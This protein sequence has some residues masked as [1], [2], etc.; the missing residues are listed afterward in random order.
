MAV[1]M[2]QHFTFS[3]LI[4]FALPTVGM[5]LFM[6]AYAMV[7]GFFVSNFAGKTALAAVN[8]VYPI[9]MIMG[10]V[11][12]M[13]GTGG[14]AVVAKT[15]GEG[16]PARANR[17]FSL[18]VYAAITAAVVFTVIGFVA[19]RPLLVLMGAEEALFG[20]AM[21]YGV[22]LMVGIPFSILQ[23]LFQELLITAG[24]PGLGFAITVAAGVTNIVLDAV[25]VAGLGW[26]LRGAAVAT[27]IGMA[28][29]GIAPLVYFA[30]PNTSFLRL[31]EAT[32]DWRTLGHMSVNGSSEMVSNIALSVVAIAY[33]IQLLKYLGDAGVAA[34][35]VI[36]YAGGM[37][38]A[39]FMGYIVGTAP[40]MS[41]QY[42]AK[43]RVEMQSLF[44]KS[45]A[46]VA[47]SGLLM[48]VAVQLL[49]RTVAQVFVGYDASLVEL[50]VH[51]ARFFAPAVT[52]MGFNMYAS[53]L[54]TSLG[55]GGISAVIAFVR[56]FICEIVAVLL[57]PVWLGSNGIWLSVVVAEIVALSLATFLLLR[58][59]PR[60]QYIAVGA[61]GVERGSLRGGPGTPQSG[62]NSEH[63]GVN[64]SAKNERF[65]ADS[66]GVLE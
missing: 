43:N 20:S 57:L 44:R 17:Q 1:D 21:A 25:F 29:G 13:L 2:S 4:K 65:D 6:S 9:F 63:I 15:R 40:L 5:M 31:G 53:A 19:L 32:L 52:L 62:Q 46:I 11:G 60:Y 50:T 36:M 23:Y 37:F 24:K 12:F 59:A 41:F 39:I 30:L 61:H 47:G 49:A 56:T 16:D 3:K 58:F 66:V 18:L 64:G 42:G 51:A 55:N 35:G 28:V 45:L 54:F 22:V 34:Y 10:T 38:A 48:F 14:G 27:V 8:F 33:N 7:D 26:G